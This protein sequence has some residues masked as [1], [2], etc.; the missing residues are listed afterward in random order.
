[1]V[2]HGLMHGMMQRQDAHVTQM[3][4]VGNRGIYHDGWMAATTPLVGS[5]TRRHPGKLN[6]EL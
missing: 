3:F 2:F 6:W 1:M 5:R 4:E